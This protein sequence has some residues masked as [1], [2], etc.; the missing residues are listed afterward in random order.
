M[1]LF[2]S[3]QRRDFPLWLYRHTARQLLVCAANLINRRRA[4]GVMT[5]FIK[6]K[7]H[8]G[9]PLNE[10]ADA[11]RER[12][13]RWTLLGRKMWIQRVYISITVNTGG[14]ER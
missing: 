9:E 3:M 6:V 10:A 12:R 7:A 4:N 11:W 14:V 2:Q 8:S 1:T 5:R 13:H